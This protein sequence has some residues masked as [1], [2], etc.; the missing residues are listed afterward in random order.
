MILLMRFYGL[1]VS[2]VATLERQR[3][4]SGHIAIR[5]MKND[6]WLWMPLYP[7]V[8]EALEMIPLPS[9]QESRYFFW[10]GRGAREI[11]INNTIMSLAAV[12]RASKVPQATSHRFRHTLA[13]ELLSKGAGMEDVADILGDDPETIRE[14]YKHWM[15]EYQ[16]R[17]TALL[18]R[19]HGS[20]TPMA[21]SKSDGVNGVFSGRRM[22][23]REGFEPSVQ[24]LSRTT[25]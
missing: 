25:V 11:H 1:R 21:H 3:V 10:S 4:K 12:Y 23:E 24:G 8:S 16:E 20:G 5:A 13:M 15:P 9:G 17:A 7:E 14:H 22:A 2:D 6:R 18:N 19:V